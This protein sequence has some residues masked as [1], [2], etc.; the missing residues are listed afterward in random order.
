MTTSNWKS[1]VQEYA[2]QQVRQPRVTYNTHRVGGHDHSPDFL[3]HLTVGSVEVRAHGT[4]KQNAEKEAAK[5]VA[6]KLKIPEP[7]PTDEMLPLGSYQDDEMPELENALESDRYEGARVY[8]PESIWASTPRDDDYTHQIQQARNGAIH[9]PGAASAMHNKFTPLF[10]FP[11][12]NYILQVNQGRQPA[13]LNAELPPGVH[14]IGIFNEQTRRH[15][16]V[17]DFPD[18]VTVVKNKNFLINMVFFHVGQLS[19]KNEKI[20]LVSPYISAMPQLCQL[21][22][23]VCPELKIEHVLPKFV[24]A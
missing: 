8:P 15:T 5:I 17:Q 13:R 9:S 21:L 16:A 14:C 7:I 18:W 12:A 11:A 10:N 24:I 3:C 2:A 22:M 1:T 20:T 6:V 19:M 23:D 4:S